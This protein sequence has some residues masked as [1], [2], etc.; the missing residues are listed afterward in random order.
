MHL[1]GRAAKLIVWLE[2][3]KEKKEPVCEPRTSVHSTAPCVSL[4]RGLGW[5]PL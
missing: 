1:S 3:N 2:L 4:A 5:I